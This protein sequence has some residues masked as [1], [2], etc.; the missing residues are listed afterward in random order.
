M[1]AQTLNI[2]HVTRENALEKVGERKLQRLTARDL[3][4]GAREIG[5]RLRGSVE[6]ALQVA[7]DSRPAAVFSGI[8]RFRVPNDAAG[9]QRV[10]GGAIRG[11]HPER[12]AVLADLACELGRR[13]DCHQAAAVKDADAVTQL[14]R[15]LGV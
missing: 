12:K 13:T 2:G 6:S 8:E 15:L 11:A 7:L 9:H 1:S 14:E 5:D 10:D 3:N 4:A